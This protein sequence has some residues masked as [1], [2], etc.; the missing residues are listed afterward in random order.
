[1][2]TQDEGRD[3]TGRFPTETAGLPDATRSDVVDLVDGDIYELEI[4]AVRKLIDGSTVRMLAYSGSIPGPTLRVARARRCPSAP[5]TGATTKPPFTGM[6]CGSTT[7][8]T[9][10]TRRRR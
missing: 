8:T 9:A 4:G 7:D 10:R 2:A 3:A 5:L 1:M 6:A